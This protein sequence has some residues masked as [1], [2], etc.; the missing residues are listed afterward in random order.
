MATTKQVKQI[1]DAKGRIIGG[2]PPVGFHTNPERRSDGGWK[3]E[4]SISYQYNKMLRMTQEEVL[5]YNPQTV[6][7]TVAKTRILEML[8][9]NNVTK[10]QALDVTKEITDRTEGKA[11]QYTD[12]TSKDESLS[13]LLVKFIDATTDNSN[14]S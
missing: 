14:S 5:A 7:Q 9:S 11:K 4:D 6:A 13:P 8:E 1:R 12:V 3:K 2:T 10:G